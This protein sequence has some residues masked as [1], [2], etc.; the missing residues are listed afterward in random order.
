MEQPR[1]RIRAVAACAAL[2]IGLGAAGADA[3]PVFDNMKCYKI[4]DGVRSK[5]YTADLV[6]KLT[7][8]FA[9]QLGDRI[10]GG[11]LVKGCRIKTPAKFFCTDVAAESAHDVLPPYDPTQ[12]VVPGPESGDRLCYKLICPAE[13]PKDLPVIDAFGNRTIQLR[14]R[15]EYFCT[16][17]VRQNPS[18]DPCDMAGNGQCGGVCANGQVCLAT[19]PSGCGC[20]DP[21]EGCSVSQTCGAGFCGGVWETCVALPGG[22]CGC[23]HP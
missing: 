2:L 20:V 7:H 1:R 23:S 21:S 14:G 18:T 8:D 15:T 6:P 17:V 13:L 16:P 3:Q 22:G 19:S 9:T 12:W 11:F 5:Q 4:K 10:V